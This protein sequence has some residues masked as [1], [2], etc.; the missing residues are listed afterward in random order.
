MTAR[1]KA[2]E[3]LLTASELEIVKA[4][5]SPAIKGLTTQQLKS[6]VSRLRQAHGRAKDISA[7]QRREIRGKA[8]PRGSRRV[9]DNTG[10]VEKAKT[11]L[12][13]KQRVDEELARRVANEKK[14]V[15][16]AELSR[17][18]LEQ[19]RKNQGQ[20]QRPSTQRTASQ[21][22][23][24]KQRKKPVKIGTSRKEIGRVTKAGKVAQARRDARRG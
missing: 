14:A 10:S 17:R 16:Q 3:R 12:Q 21:G 6:L 13:A 19:K 4:T 11:L 23:R 9:K 7:R 22:M 1:V 8:D 5:R 24:P 2:E 20:Q 18:A 15:S